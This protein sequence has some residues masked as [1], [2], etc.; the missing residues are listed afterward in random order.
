MTETQF[1]DMSFK[2][3]NRNRKMSLDSHF[4]QLSTINFADL[5]GLIKVV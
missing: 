2:I 1:N 3:L 4:N 5:L